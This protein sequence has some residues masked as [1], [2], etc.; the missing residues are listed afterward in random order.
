MLKMGRLKNKVAFVTA[1]G[2]GI[3]RSICAHFVAEGAF[4][5]A[6]DIDGALAAQ[7]ISELS[8]PA[9]IGMSCDVSNGDSVRAALKETVKHFGRLDVLC[10]LAGGSSL[11]DARVTD[12]PDE[13][14][15][16]VANVD[17]FGT[18][19]CCK[20]GIPYLIAAGGGSIINMGS[21]VEQ[22]ALP[23]RDCYTAA[24]G[25]VMAIT[26]SMA[27]EYASCAIRVNAIAPGITLT[28]RVATRI[29]MRDSSDR[30][31]ANH[32]LGLLLPEDVAH[33]AVFLASDES[34]RFTGQIL[35]LDSGASVAGAN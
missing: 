31:I 11:E 4:V 8:P 15:W 28:P 17:L 12:A 24:K 19:L 6:T 22:L 27:A 21:I 10:N 33:L 14:F 3:G 20:Y 16:R 18:F 25:G 26:R 9:V 29:A 35:A 13:E 2:G 30:L 5:A 7:A 34:R 1:A 32:L 23:G